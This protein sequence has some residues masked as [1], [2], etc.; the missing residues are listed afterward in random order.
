MATTEDIQQLTGRL[1]LDAD[2]RAEFARDPVAAAR[3][4]GIELDADQAESFKQNM[5]RVVDA[6]AELEKAEV[7]AHGHAVAVF[8]NRPEK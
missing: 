7:S 6:A 2:F 5:D 8:A 3:T 4:A 1:M